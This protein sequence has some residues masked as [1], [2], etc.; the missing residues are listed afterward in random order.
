M[1]WWKISPE[2]EL[3]EDDLQEEDERYKKKDRRKRRGCSE[4]EEEEGYDFFRYAPGGPRRSFGVFK[5]M[6]WFFRK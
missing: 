6:R 5:V 1:G 2:D 4:D 3:E